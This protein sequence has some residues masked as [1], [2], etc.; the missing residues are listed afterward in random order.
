MHIVGGKKA[1]ERRKTLGG[2]EILHEKRFKEFTVYCL[3]PQYL[4][5]S[6]RYFNYFDSDLVDFLLLDDDS[7]S[8]LVYMTCC[9][10]EFL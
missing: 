7:A 9:L 1:P 6:S 2:G 4:S 8:R 3:S 5:N 10:A